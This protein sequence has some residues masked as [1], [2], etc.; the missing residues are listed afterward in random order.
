MARGATWT[1]SDGLKVPFG[2]HTADN[3]VPAVTAADGGVK[4]MVMEIVGTELV[5]TFAAAN[6][7]AEAPVIRRGSSILSAKLM[8]TEAF[9]GA[10]ATLDLGL[11]GKTAGVIDDADGIDVDIAVTAIDAIGDVVVCDGALVNGVVAVGA[12][13]NDDCVIAPSYETA[14]FTAGKGLLIIQYVEPMFSDSVAA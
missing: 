3:S 4:V 11:W 2:A 9:V 8:V 6:V 1:N 14:A 7:A 10:T 12:T 5:D 13:A